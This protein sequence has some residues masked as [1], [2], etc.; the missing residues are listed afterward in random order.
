MS[1]ETETKTPALETAAPIVAIPLDLTGLLK[2]LGHD[3][4]ALFLPLLNAELTALQQPGANVQTVVENAMKAK[5][6]ALAQVPQAESTGIADTAA[7]A[8][9]QLNSLVSSAVPAA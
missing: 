3:E 1:S 8:Q 6:V 4:L 7:A 9:A 2:K 5:I